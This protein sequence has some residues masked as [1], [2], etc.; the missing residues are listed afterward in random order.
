MTV[1]RRRASS[2][3]VT[4][5]RQGIGEYLPNSVAVEGELLLVIRKAGGVIQK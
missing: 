2:K 1:Q 4:G 5:T 3:D